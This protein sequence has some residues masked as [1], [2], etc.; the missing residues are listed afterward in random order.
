MNSNYFGEWEVIIID[1]MLTGLFKVYMMRRELNTKIF[2][3]HNNTMESITEGA[4]INKDDLYF[5]E[6]SLD[7]LRSFSNSLA[8]LGIKTTNDHKNEGLLE[9]T[10]YHLEDLRTLLKLKKG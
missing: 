3:T 2:M 4:E 8:E 1:D 5:A 9:A 7:Q 6:M 10:K